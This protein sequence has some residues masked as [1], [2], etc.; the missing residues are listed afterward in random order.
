[1]L[2]GFDEENAQLS[3]QLRVMRRFRK[4][5]TFSVVF[6]LKLSFSLQ[7]ANG[8]IQERLKDISELELYKKHASSQIEHYEYECRNASNERAMLESQLDKLEK[9]VEEV[10]NAALFA[11]KSGD[12]IM[13]E[14]RQLHIQ[15][16][17]HIRNSFC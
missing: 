5:F 6:F 13:R 16:H 4:H 15:L 14:N 2:L 1:M 10:R 17:E 3:D 9:E 12:K 7:L 8:Q 11:G